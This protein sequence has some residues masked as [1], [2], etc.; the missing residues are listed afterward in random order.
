VKRALKEG[1]KVYAATAGWG[2]ARKERR[3]EAAFLRCVF[4]SHCNAHLQRLHTRG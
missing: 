3:V 4:C 1:F 2:G